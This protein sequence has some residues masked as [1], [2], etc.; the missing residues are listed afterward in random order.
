MK[1]GCNRCACSYSPSIQFHI[2]TQHIG[3]GFTNR[4]LKCV[5]GYKVDASCVVEHCRLMEL[6][7]KFPSYCYGGEFWEKFGWFEESEK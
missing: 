4:A 6:L 1:I 7:R 5:D 2:E 3:T